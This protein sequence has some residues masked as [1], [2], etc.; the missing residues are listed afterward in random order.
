MVA[1][2]H[3]PGALRL[4]KEVAQ[5]LSG[6]RVVQIERMY[7][8]CLKFSQI[9]GGPTFQFPSPNPYSWAIKWLHKATTQ[10]LSD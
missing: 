3:Y 8:K 7:G 2:S 6:R 10:V 5:R 1:Q 4:V 9:L